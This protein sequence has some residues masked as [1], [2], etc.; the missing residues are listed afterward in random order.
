MKA[1]GDGRLPAPAAGAA[2]AGASAGARTARAER[3]GSARRSAER[4]SAACSRRRTASCSGGS[5]RVPRA[6]VIWTVATMLPGCSAA[7]E[8]RDGER[9]S[10]SAT[11]TTTRSSKPARRAGCPTVA[12]KSSAKVSCATT[13]SPGSASAAGAPHARAASSGSGGTGPCPPLGG[14]A[15]VGAWL[16]IIGEPGS[17]PKSAR[18][19][20]EPYSASSTGG[21]GDAAAWRGAACCG[22][23]GDAASACCCTCGISGERCSKPCMAASGGIPMKVQSAE[24]PARCGVASMVLRN[25]SRPL[26]I[27]SWR[28]FLSPGG[29]LGGSGG[30][31][32]NPGVSLS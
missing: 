30:M 23:G 25:I 26:R 16:P 29:F 27:V 14:A 32:G 4:A 24:F 2:G 19:S 22:G 10:A 3:L 8:T 7:M 18:T 11:A 21:G 20:A 31:G 1:L 9:R 28:V 6:G 5:L 12:P 13:A 17:S 15:G